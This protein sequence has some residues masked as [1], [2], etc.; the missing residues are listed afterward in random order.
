ML[1]YPKLPYNTLN[2]KADVLSLPNKLC[3]PL[4]QVGR[5]HWNDATC[6]SS[7]HLDSERKELSVNGENAVLASERAAAPFFVPHLRKRHPLLINSRYSPTSSSTPGCF[8][9]SSFTS[10]RCQHCVI[11]ER[12]FS[13]SRPLCLVA[14][15]GPESS[16]L[17]WGTSGS[18]DLYPSICPAWVTLPGEE[19]PAGKAPGV[20][21]AHEAED[22]DKVAILP[23]VCERA[24]GGKSSVI[25]MFNSVC[26][27][28][29]HSFRCI[30]FFFLH[31]IFSCPQG[32]C[33]GC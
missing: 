33:S 12:P 32:S 22:H 26:V 11:F 8:P 23:W 2:E 14:G 10:P 28:E 18:R 25:L 27:C 24:A 21:E 31:L 13:L 20:P 4:N 17:T 3:C 29:F 9:I 1:N 7:C 5:V 30:I 16:P 15:V 19:P 6:L